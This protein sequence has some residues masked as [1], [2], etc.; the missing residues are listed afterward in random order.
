MEVLER[1]VEGRVRKIVKL[2]SITFTF[3]RSK[4][5]ILC[6]LQNFDRHFIKKTKTVQDNEM[7]SIK[8]E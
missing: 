8:I 3:K 6:N 4:S 7:V 1:V 2:D 5:A